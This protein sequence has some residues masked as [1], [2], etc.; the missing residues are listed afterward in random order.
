LF[1]QQFYPDFRVL[2]FLVA[3]AAEGAFAYPFAADSITSDADE[4]VLISIDKL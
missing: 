4:S 2:V 1:E 3:F